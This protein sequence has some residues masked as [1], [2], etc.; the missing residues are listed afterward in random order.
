MSGNIVFGCTKSSDVPDDH[1][2]DLWANNGDDE[3]HAVKKAVLESHST[4][5]KPQLF[6]PEFMQDSDYRHGVTSS[7]T[8]TR[9]DAKELIY[10]NCDNT[11]SANDEN[12]Y[13]TSHGSYKPGQ[14]RRRNYN[15]PVNPSTIFG[16][17][18]KGESGKSRGS[19]IGV[20]GALHMKDEGNVVTECKTQDPDRIFGKSTS[21]P[22]SSA[23]DCLCHSTSGEVDDI[24]KS[25]TPGFRNASTQRI[26]GC[27]SIRTDIPKYGT[28]S[29]ADTQNYGDDV[30]AGYLLRPSLFSSFGLEEDE[31]LKPRSKGYLKRLFAS[32]GLK[33]DDHKFEE[34]FN[35]V[36]DSDSASIASFQN[37]VEELEA[38]SNSS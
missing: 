11:N 37:L 9:E 6:F 22:N 21:S 26:F 20:A 16:I 38:S 32:C 18:G 30:N 19:S 7:N 36:S 27:P 12:N 33:I 15:W 1:V 5:S 8:K 3:Y 14:Q 31:F 24:G 25:L 4:L 23:A 2:E 13:I 35:R 34:T 29:V 10:S 17:K 28:V